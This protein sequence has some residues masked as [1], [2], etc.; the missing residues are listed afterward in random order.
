MFAVVYV[1]L[2]SGKNVAGQNDRQGKNMTG[3]QAFLAGHY[4]LTVC[5]RAVTRALIGGGGGGVNIHI[6]VLCPITVISFEI[7]LITL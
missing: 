4:P 2:R 7:I 6:F 1:F 3:Q 5:Y